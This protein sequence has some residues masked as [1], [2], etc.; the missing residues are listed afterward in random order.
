[1]TRLTAAK[2]IIAACGLIVW[3]FGVRT[4]QSVYQYVGIALMVVAVLV[5]FFRKRDVEG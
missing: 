2:L 5:R 1:M 4:S 3:G